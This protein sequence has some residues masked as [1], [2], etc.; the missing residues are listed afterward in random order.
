MGINAE[1]PKGFTLDLEGIT[2]TVPDTKYPLWNG[3]YG[4]GQLTIYQAEQSGIAVVSG[5]MAVIAVYAEEGVTE[6]FLTLSWYE[7]GTG[8]TAI[9]DSVQGKIIGQY[10]S[11]K[12]SIAINTASAGSKTLH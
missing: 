7:A 10:C 1:E 8:A 9:I 4:T 3:S 2:L 11:A 6:D 12:A 5:T